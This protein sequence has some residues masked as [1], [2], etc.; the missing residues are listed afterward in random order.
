MIEKAVSKRIREL[1]H[2]KRMS[3]YSLCHAAG[4]PPSTISS[5]LNGKSRNPG[6]VTIKM[7]CDGLEISIPDFFNCELFA[8]VEQEIY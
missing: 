7:I 3:I 8:E 2:A 6:I 4:M 1:C 5:L